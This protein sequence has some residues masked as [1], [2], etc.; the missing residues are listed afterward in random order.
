MK[1][2]EYGSY[3]AVGLGQLVAR[4]EVSP[5]ELALTARQAIEALDPKLKAVV[6]VYDDQIDDL[7]EARLGNGPLRGVPFLIKDMFGHEQ[8]R[9]I[10]FGSRL[11]RDMRVE[12]GTYL[13]DHF[14]DAGLNILGRSHAPEYSMAATTE[15]AMYGN[16]CNPWMDGYSAGG[17]SGGAQAAVTAGLVPLAHGSDIGG[18]IRIPASWCGGV[19]LKASR[20]RISLG[21][22]VDEAGFGY[23]S[24]LVQAKTVRDVA[25]ALDCVSQPMPGDPFVIPRPD[26]SYAT[27][28]ETSVTGLRIGIVLDELTGMAVDPEVVA[29][30]HQ[31][32]RVLSDMG[33]HVEVGDADMGGPKI[34]KATTD[35]FFFGFDDRLEGFAA[36]SGRAIGPDTLEPTILS[37]YEYAKTITAKQFLQTW[38][39]LNV[40]R[41]SLARFWSN[42][43]IWLSPTTARVAEP[44]GTYHLS[45]PGVTASNVADELYRAPVQFTIPH[46]IMGAPAIS[47]PLAMHTSGLPIGVQLAAPPAQDHVVLQ[48][49]RALEQAMPWSQRKPAFHI[50]TAED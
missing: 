48:L 45:K 3:D 49:A 44:W 6:E 23:S 30:V 31:T 2:R 47:L 10:E 14:K 42:F 16:C 35:I 9:R 7:D 5:R 28:S 15:T 21:P 43:D 25:V 33:H 36:L 32:A 1:L 46:N 4:G 29:A 12:H 50:A 19:G 34:L 37:L 27:L 39:D 20:G 24:N 26:D 22:I 17:S 13:V 41:R 40:A 11:C 18:S 8:G 38:S